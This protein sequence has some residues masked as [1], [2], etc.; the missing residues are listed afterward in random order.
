QE[1]PFSFEK[2]ASSQVLGK[3]LQQPFFTTLRTKQQTAY[4]A[5]SGPKLVENQLMQYFSV[6]SSTH[7]GEELLAR[8]ELFL[9][10]Y[11]KDIESQISKE[12]FESIRSNL[13]EK[14]QVP[15]TNLAV[16]SQK[17]HQL[18]YTFQE[19]FDFYDKE[20]KALK[21]LTYEQFCRDAKSF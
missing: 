14:L 19:D 13:I 7:Q 15:S 4:I 18:A 20:I 11:A 1:G 9:E 21:N 3:A 12:D 16:F 2:L 8:F 6:H 10:D 5:K 17:L